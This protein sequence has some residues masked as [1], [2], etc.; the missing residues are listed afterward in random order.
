MFSSYLVRLCKFLRL[1]VELFS[2]LLCLLKSFDCYKQQMVKR[3]SC[4]EHCYLYRSTNL[5]LKT[6]SHNKR[7]RGGTPPFPVSEKHQN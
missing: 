2:D 4:N 6:L 1:I 7:T 5:N 3:L